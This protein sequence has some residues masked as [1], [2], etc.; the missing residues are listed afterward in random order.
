[1]SAG[2]YKSKRDA[3][4]YLSEW[5][6]SRTLST[7]E[8]GKDVAHLVFVF[9]GSSRGAEDECPH[10][11]LCAHEVYRSSF[12]KSKLGSHETSFGM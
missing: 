4:A 2:K 1:M 8:A 5:P 11:N 3:T 10:K 12:I 9:P 7:P 6:K